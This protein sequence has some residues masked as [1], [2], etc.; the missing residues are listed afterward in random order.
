MA[1][2]NRVGVFLYN[3]GLL[4]TIGIVFL[5]FKNYNLEDPQAT[6]D[7]SKNIKYFI[8]VMLGLYYSFAAALTL[9]A[10][11]SKARKKGFIFSVMM[12]LFWALIMVSVLF[13]FLPD[14]LSS[15]YTYPGMRYFMVAASIGIA[16]VP[17]ILLML[18]MFPGGVDRKYLIKEVTKNLQNEQKKSKP[19]CPRCKFPSEKEWKHCPK[20]GAHFSD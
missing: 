14:I 11:L 17:A 16:F 19:F 13:A 8:F 10:F 6:V 1:I 15:D 3:I 20:C 12:I 2:L 4:L 5:C 7:F 9:A 18:Y